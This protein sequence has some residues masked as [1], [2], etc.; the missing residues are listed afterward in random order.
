M[1]RRRWT[2][3]LLVVVLI[4]GLA[5][6][7]FTSRG[8]VIPGLGSPGDERAVLSMQLRNARSLWD[9][10]RPG[11][12]QIVVR[13]EDATRHVE[14]HTLS[15]TKGEVT[16]TSSRCE[17]TASESAPCEVWQV[18]P[19]AYTV[20]G[21]FDTARSLLGRSI[22]G[23]VIR[24]SFDETYGYPRM[25]SIDSPDG[26]HEEQRWEVESFTSR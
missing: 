20:P 14:W 4:G 23:E 10:Q 11:S 9:R 8:L 25:M 22:P 1:E 12:Y 18:D 19:A 26:A 21:L 3:V 6:F 24:L 13:H 15:V 16:E 5:A 7:V 2:M 17:A